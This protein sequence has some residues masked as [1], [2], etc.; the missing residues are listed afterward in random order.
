MHSK[1]ILQWLHHTELFES[2]RLRY[3]GNLETSME[4]SE[5]YLLIS[6]DVLQMS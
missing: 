3:Q 5:F 2:L 6:T 4:T 1:K